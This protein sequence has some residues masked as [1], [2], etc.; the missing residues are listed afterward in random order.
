M[1]R[2]PWHLSSAADGTKHTGALPGSGFCAIR[3]TP[4][5]SNGNGKLLLSTG[6]A[7]AAGAIVGVS[8]GLAVCGKACADGS[9][10]IAKQ[11]ETQMSPPATGAFGNEGKLQL[12]SALD[13]QAPAFVPSV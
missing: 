6:G 2:C 4:R 7:K 9:G 1:Q 5:G 13:W 8:S 3:M 11:V 10:G 12:A